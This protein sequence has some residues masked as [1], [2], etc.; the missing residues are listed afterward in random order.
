MDD[1]LVSLNCEDSC[2]DDRRFDSLTRQL[3]AG[4]SRRSV[5]KG[6]LG[7]G[8]ALAPASTL[9]ARRPEPTPKPVKCPQRQHWDGYECVCDD[10]DTCGSDCCIGESVCCDNACCFGTCY[11][12]ELCCPAEKIVCNGECLPYGVQCNDDNCCDAGEICVEGQC[13]PE[14]D[15]V[16]IGGACTDNSDCCSGI[17]S[18]GLCWATI[19]GSCSGEADFCAYQF[20]DCNDFSGSRLSYCKCY[21]DDTAT[22]ICGIRNL[23]VDSCDECPAGTYCQSDCPACGWGDGCIYPCPPTLDR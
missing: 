17:C 21:A 6:L 2:M 3:G 11:G 7:F 5:V 14:C 10:G 20:E 16:A 9:A 8:G 18:A 1:H 22:T 19:G 13:V 23:C 4:A 15:G 12:E